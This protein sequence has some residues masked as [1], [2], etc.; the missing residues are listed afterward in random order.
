MPGSA[1]SNRAM[2]SIVSCNLFTT[3]VRTNLPYAPVLPPFLADALLARLG[4][5]SPSSP[6][7]A[8]CVQSAFLTGETLRH[9]QASQ[10]LR[11]PSLLPSPVPQTASL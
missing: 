9:P 1:S 11:S 2:A 8:A 3:V 5:P 6:M 10:R 4:P 7:C